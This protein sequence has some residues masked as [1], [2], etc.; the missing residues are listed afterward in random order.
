MRRIAAAAL[1]ALVVAPLWR[2]SAARAA[3]DG[4]L[5]DANIV[6]I[7]DMADITAARL[8]MKLAASDEFGVLATLVLNDQVAVPGNCRDSANELYRA[9]LTHEVAFHQGVIEVIKGTILP[10]VG[11]PRLKALITV[12]LRP[13][14]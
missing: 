3:A 11:D 1:A 4:K 14:V 9:Y 6:H 8:G 10:V 12:V 5:S 13:D 7:F 2:F